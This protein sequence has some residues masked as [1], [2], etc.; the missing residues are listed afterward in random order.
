VSEP[1]K[2][3]TVRTGWRGLAP[4]IAHEQTTLSDP[5]PVDVTSQAPLD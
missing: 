4:I 1:I 3:G 5:V 2:F